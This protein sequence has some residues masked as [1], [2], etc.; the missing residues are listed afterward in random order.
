MGDIDKLAADQ[1]WLEKDELNFEFE[2][3]DSVK[4]ITELYLSKSLI[5]HRDQ[6][7]EEERERAS[8]FVK[9][10]VALLKSTQ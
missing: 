8:L 6:D 5:F 1:G 7:S 3:A 2:S 4:K 9:F 10:M